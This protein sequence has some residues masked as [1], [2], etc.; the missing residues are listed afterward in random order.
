MSAETEKEVTRSVC[1]CAHGNNH[2]EHGAPRGKE[3]E[4]SSLY[5]TYPRDPRDPVVVLSVY[6][7]EIRHKPSDS[8]SSNQNDSLQSLTMGAHLRYEFMEQVVRVVRHRPGFR[9]VLD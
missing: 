8:L 9:M 2:G 5:Q 6:A 4:K 7:I 3:S 1:N